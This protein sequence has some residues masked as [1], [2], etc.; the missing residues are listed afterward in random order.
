[1]LFLSMLPGLLALLLLAFL[2][3]EVLGVEDAQAPFIAACAAIVWLLV[4]ALLHAL[5]AGVIA[6]YLLTLLG[7]AYLLLRRKR[8]EALRAFGR[9]YPVAFFAIGALAAAL[10]AAALHPHFTVWDELSHWGPFYKLLFTTNA[11]AFQSAQVSNLVHPSYPQGGMLFYYFL[12]RP[13][14]AF[15]EPV[16]YWSNAVLLLA[17]VTS[18]TGR[19]GR[20]RRAQA[21]LAVCTL[22]V[23]FCLFV[24]TYPYFSVYQDCVL[25]AFGGALLA[26]ALS[27]PVRGVRRTAAV[28]LAL[29]AFVQVKDI[30]MLFALMICLVFIVLQL[31]A[32]GPGRAAGKAAVC[33][34]LPASSAVSYLLWKIATASIKGDAQASFSLTAVFSVLRRLLFGHDAGLRTALMNYLLALE[35]RPVLVSLGCPAWTLFVLFTAA[36]LLLAAF[37]H[38]RTRSR[39]AVCMG[40]SLPLLCAGYFAL[41][42][43]LYQTSF[44]A[45]EAA[46]LASFE[47]YVSTFF[48]LWL[49]ALLGMALGCTGGGAVFYKDAGT[50]ALAFCCVLTTLM[51]PFCLNRALSSYTQ[52]DRARYDAA[53]ARFAPAVGGGTVL[54][55]SQSS[56]GLPMFAYHYT[57]L[58][59]KVVRSLYEVGPGMTQTAFTQLLGREK[60]GF[61]LVDRSDRTL[62]TTLSPLFADGLSAASSGGP[63]LYRVENAD[64]AVRLTPVG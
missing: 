37:C 4:F 24:E 7:T 57:L 51:L 30:A 19:I 40:V 16:V 31:A 60:V 54:V 1:M 43:L 23:I 38:H 29:F 47:R 26:F 55:L 18:L 58:P 28:A 36:G 59:A 22:P 3:R 5:P 44:A 6:L 33:L 11:L 34:T 20:G 2:A 10:L 45:N 52:V 35:K 25:G 39:A 64:G 27:Q 13:T 48:I 63:C 9:S 32:G 53:A 46:Q 14:R 17:C 42:F 49:M 15:S 41:L 61:V 12:A 62:K 56:D 8:L 50:L 21:V